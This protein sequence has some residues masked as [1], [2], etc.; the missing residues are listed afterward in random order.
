MP[1]RTTVLTRLAALVPAWMILAAPDVSAREVPITILHTTDLHGR[2]VNVLPESEETPPESGLLRL[3]TLIAHERAARPRALL[4]DCGDTFQ[5]S[6]ESLATKGQVILDAIRYLRYDAWV[7]GNHEFDFGLAQ[8]AAWQAAMPASCAILGANLHSRPGAPVPV[9]PRVQ[10]FV[11]REVDGVRI[12]LVGLTTPGIPSWLLPDY[13]GDL[14][15]TRSLDELRNI[16]PAVRA[17]RPDVLILLAHQGI[18]PERDNASEVTAIAREVP[19]FDII[20]GGHTHE[21][22]PSMDLGGVLFSQAGCHGAFLG[23]VELVYDTGARRVVRKSA[24]LEPV[25]AETP[26][27]PGLQRR[28]ADV[29]KKVEAGLAAS[30][31][32]LAGPLDAEPG[33]EGNSGAERLLRAVIADASH[34]E[35]VV[36]GTLSRAGLPEGPVTER[37]I[38][39]IVPFENRIGVL[40]LTTA[41]LRPI[42]DEIC[43]RGA[44]GRGMGLWGLWVEADPEAPAGERIVRI[45]LPDGRTPHPRRRFRVAFNSHALASGGTRFPALRAA[46]D[47]P[48]ARAELL[49]VLTRDLVRA[50]LIKNNPFD[51]TTLPASGL[52]RVRRQPEKANRPAEEIPAG[53]TR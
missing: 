32:R 19:E 47:N 53:S 22:I 4:V 14:L 23:V 27:D 42:L 6:P 28:C 3:A 36:H 44:R 45:A 48:E 46:W 34:A 41:E 25:T 30:V 1:T 50:Y 13:L 38:W 15:V 9:L 18:R 16:L 40:S 11:I 31:G 2:M 24:R 21:A 33:W 39:K 17:A 35:V 52:S 43:G 49:P 26:T 37:D 51:P 8:A 7:M 5:G 20:L 12:A 10:P 29:L